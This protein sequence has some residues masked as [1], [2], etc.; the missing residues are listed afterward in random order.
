MPL[1]K[2]LLLLIALGMFPFTLHAAPL[3]VV[4]I[5]QDFASIAQSIGGNHVRVTSL[6]K[7]SQDLHHVNAKPSMVMTVKNADLLIRLGM[8]QDGWVDDLIR[9][10][11]NRGI[12]PGAKGYLDASSRII[13]LD[14]PSQIDGQG[15]IHKYGNPHY[16]LAP[17]NG[18]IIAQEIADQLSQLDPSNTPQYAGNLAKFNKQMDQKIAE[19]RLKLAPLSGTKFVTYH[20]EWRYFL[21]EF[22]LAEVGRLEPLPGV[23]P[24]LRHMATLKQK[25]MAYP[26][27]K[28]LTADFYDAAV[29]TQFAKQSQCD[30]IIVP[31]NVGGGGTQ[32]YIGL[33][34]T[35]VEKVSTRD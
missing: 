7:G 5:N 20:G 17:S 24:T 34:D 11:G 19:W 8:D 10:S 1:I 3:Q 4:A 25:F 31:A 13:K 33:I 2:Y 28:V 18:K 32:D 14:V 23:P 26:Q 30:A 21:D 15:D 6:V 35:I 22:K 29:V 16:W 9:K 12:L 27:R